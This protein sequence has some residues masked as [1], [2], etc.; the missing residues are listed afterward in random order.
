MGFPPSDLKIWVLAIV[1]L[2]SLGVGYFLGQGQQATDG[3]REHGSAVEPNSGPLIGSRRPDFALPDLQEVPRSIGEWDGMLLVINF[4]ATWCPPCRK[5]I[6]VFIDLQ[7]KYR[8]RG[9]RFVGVAIDDLEAVQKYAEEVGINYPILHGDIEAFEVSRGYGNQ[10]GAL[11]FTVVIDRKGI[12]VLS[13][14][15]EISRTEVEQ[16]IQT[17]LSAW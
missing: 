8:G 17:Y 10:L 2:T 13:R 6:P 9:L 15:G 16:V 3:L 14:P 1:G 11:P 4:W 12:I 7:E 5:E